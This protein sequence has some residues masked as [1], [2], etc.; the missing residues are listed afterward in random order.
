MS[1][2]QIIRFENMLDQLITKVGYLITQMH[3]FADGM[4]LLEQKINGLEVRMERLEEKVDRLEVR[5]ER[6]EEKV[7]HL[8]G[9][10]ERLEVKVDRL[11]VQMKQ[12]QTEIVDLRKEVRDGFQETGARIDQIENRLE[13]HRNQIAENK[14]DIEMVKKVFWERIS[15]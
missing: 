12:M 9:R 14:E 7:D 5:I 4:A 3:S 10:I 6:L 8:E 15:V 13:I 2:D 1:E 11:E